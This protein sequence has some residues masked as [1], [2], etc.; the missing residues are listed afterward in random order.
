VIVG[1]QIDKMLGA[2]VGDAFLCNFGNP[3]RND[4]VFC[5]EILTQKEKE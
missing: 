5:D 2:K 1:F 3:N 4:F